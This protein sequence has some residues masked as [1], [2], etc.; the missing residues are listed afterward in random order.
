MSYSLR[1]LVPLPHPTASNWHTAFGCSWC[2]VPHQVRLQA[3]TFKL[4][5]HR[6][7]LKSS[8]SFK[9][10]LQIPHA[11]LRPVRNVEASSNPLF[12]P[13]QVVFNFSDHA[14]SHSV[15]FPP[16]LIPN[17]QHFFIL[18]LSISTC[19]SVPRSPSVFACHCI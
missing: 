16:L 3:I 14:P 19:V 10:S 2:L 8:L 5:C 17:C 1:A 15:K 13:L 6:R 9:A 18:H 4:L 11:A 7:H 12:Q